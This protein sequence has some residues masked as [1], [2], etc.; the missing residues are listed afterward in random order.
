MQLAGVERQLR[1]A[2]QSLDESL[3]HA[4]A[5]GF[6]PAYRS[7]LRS[8]NLL[9]HATRGLAA[10]RGQELPEMPV[11][12]GAPGNF[13]DADAALAALDAALAPFPDP[14]LAALDEKIAAARAPYGRWLGFL[15]EEGRQLRNGLKV[16]AAVAARQFRGSLPRFLVADA[17]V[18]ARI[19][20]ANVGVADD[21][22]YYWEAARRF[23]AADSS[24]LYW[25]V[26][27]SSSADFSIRRRASRCSFYFRCCR[28]WPR[29]PF[30]RWASP[31]C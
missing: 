26:R 27:R 9:F 18:L 16:V 14:E 4:R 19:V 6:D 13:D 15:R 12:A 10:A 30:A 7:A 21:F 8:R 2:R 28:S 11:V 24:S 29:H 3:A 20:G 31:R 22:H 1:E 17:R 25:R 5:G 23:L